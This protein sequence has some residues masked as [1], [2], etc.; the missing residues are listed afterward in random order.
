MTK[1]LTRRQAA[2]LLSIAPATLSAWEYRARKSGRPDDAPPS[3]KVGAK[4]RRYE[5]ESLVRWIATRAKAATR[6]TS[7][8][9]RGRTGR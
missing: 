2:E 6:T 4:L 5:E 9:H 3:V 1:F 8:R 7:K